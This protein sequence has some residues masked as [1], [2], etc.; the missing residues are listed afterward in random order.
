MGVG[1]WAEVDVAGR[2]KV[3]PKDIYRIENDDT[4]LI[5]MSRKHSTPS[6]QQYLL[7]VPRKKYFRIF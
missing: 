5:F 3:R 1:G 4:L 2:Y 7:K 6:C